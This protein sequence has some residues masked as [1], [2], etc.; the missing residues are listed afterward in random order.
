MALRQITFE[1]LKK[2]RLS[3]VL[4]NHIRE[5]ILQG[6]LQPDDT[7]PTE[8]EMSRQF[9]VSPVTVRE[10]LRGL[11]AF[12]LI[13]KRQGKYGGSVV[14]QLESGTVKT[15]LY[16]FLSSKRLS[17]KDLMEARLAIEPPIAAIAASAITDVEIEE[18]EANVRYREE[19]IRGAGDS[20]TK[21]DL[22]DITEK[23]IQFHRLVGIATHNPI[24]ALTM[25][26][27]MD[28]LWDLRK[29]SGSHTS[30]FRSQVVQS[31][32]KI[33]EQLKDRQADGAEEEMRLALK[34]LR[35]RA[36]KE[37]KGF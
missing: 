15:A 5:L 25:D 19:K 8:K 26:Y 6:E 29:K 35:A 27:I 22:V 33:L 31:H 36:E 34:N 12:G 30:R 1:P 37:L 17:A 14:K 11:E 21:A 9:G 10:A 23:N 20:L 3:E 13:E 18:I 24:L 7:L 4:E 2:R 28:F 16:D 32:R